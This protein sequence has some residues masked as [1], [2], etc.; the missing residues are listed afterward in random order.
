MP[1]EPKV[2]M[3]VLDK[4]VKKVLAHKPKKKGKKH[5]LQAMPVRLS[6]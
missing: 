1:D 5:S 3:K 6:E 4:A 2:D